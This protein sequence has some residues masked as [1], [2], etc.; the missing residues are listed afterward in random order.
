MRKLIASLLCLTL[1]L[2]ACSPTAATPETGLTESPSAEA[3]ASEN[4][5]QVEASREAVVSEIENDVT[6]KIESFSEFSSA[7]VGMII[8]VGG[9]IQTGAD[10]RAKINLSPE[11]TIVRVG[12][13]SSFT[14]SKIE[15][16]NG[17]PKTTLQLLFGKVFILL[18]GG[19][20]DVETP[21]G[22]AS[23]RGSLLSVQY[24]PV[25]NRVR[26]SCLEG[27]CSLE[28][29]DGEEVELIEGESAFIDEEGLLSDVTEIDQDEIVDWLEENPELNEFMEELPNPEEFPDFAD[30]E[31]YIEWTVEEF[32]TEEFPT[33]ES[34]TEEPPTEE[35][36]TEEA[37]TEEPP[38]DDGG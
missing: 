36:P 13:N 18:N 5:Q 34:P 3:T 32:P 20:L 6:A 7:T 31:W 2:V 25:T 10:S 38:P 17:E 28:N 26:A 14:L 19:S 11:N 8:P 12:P 27:E 9:I 33:E 29:E 22:V 16:E 24:D 30:D 1:L 15:N 23:V 37:P 35:P 4:N 21:S